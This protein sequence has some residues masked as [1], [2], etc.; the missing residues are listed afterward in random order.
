MTRPHGLPARRRREAAGLLAA[1][2]LAA[3]G[4]GGGGGDGAASS[5]PTSA[6]VQVRAMARGGDRLLGPT[7]TCADGAPGDITL[8]CGVPA[9][10]PRVPPLPVQPGERIELRFEAD[11]ERLLV[12]LVRAGRAGPVVQVTQLSPVRA[13]DDRRRWTIQAPGRIPRETVVGL[14]ALYDEVHIRHLP[15]GG[16]ARLENAVIQFQ[17]PLARAG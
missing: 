9:A 12:Q 14:V 3:I 16:T 2:G 7:S 11:V 17:L 15:T 6:T 10:H 8:A 5:E 4:C 1:L 13:P